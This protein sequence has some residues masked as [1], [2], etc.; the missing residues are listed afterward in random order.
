MNPTKPGVPRN[1]GGAL[2]LAFPLVTRPRGDGV[3]RD[4]DLLTAND[5][6]APR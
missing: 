3:D 4:P 1:V 6:V 2:F 5:A